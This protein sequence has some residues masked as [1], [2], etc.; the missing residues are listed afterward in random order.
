MIIS[1]GNNCAPRLNIKNE[2][3]YPFDWLV[4]GR[5]MDDQGTDNLS[6][7]C[8]NNMLTNTLKPS[9]MRFDIPRETIKRQDRWPYEMK[10]RI[11]LHPWF[12]S[13]HDLALHNDESNFQELC[14]KINR[15]L[16]R[17]K[18]LIQKERELTFVRIEFFDFDLT[19]FVEFKNIIHGLNPDLNF[20]VCLVSYNNYCPSHNYTWLKIFRLKDN[21]VKNVEWTPEWPEFNWKKIIN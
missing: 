14:D 2:T 16:D 3:T 17:L 5:L 13:L 9:D 6:M 1:I 11:V 8:V 12:I 7:K 4:T 19:D 20:K 10:N 15:R 21:Y 18:E